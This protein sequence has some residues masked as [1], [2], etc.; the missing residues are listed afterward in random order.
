VNHAAGVTVPLLVVHRL[1]H[2]PA[3][4]ICRR[5]VAEGALRE[6]HPLSTD[7]D[8]VRLAASGSLRERGSV[9]VLAEGSGSWGCCARGCRAGAGL[10]CRAAGVGGW[11]GPG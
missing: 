10:S 11:K 1:M 2:A 6:A 5:S 3:L 8:A 7:G 4:Q 9:P